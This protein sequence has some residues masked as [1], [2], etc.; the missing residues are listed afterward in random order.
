MFTQ[1]ADFIAIFFCLHSS[2]GSRCLIAKNGS[3]SVDIHKVKCFP[4]LHGPM[5]L[6]RGLSWDIK[7]ATIISLRKPLAGK[8]KIGEVMRVAE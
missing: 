2:L 4:E 7:S 5:A 1:L 3:R 6:N 8:G